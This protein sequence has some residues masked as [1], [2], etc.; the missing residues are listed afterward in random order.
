[1]GPNQPSFR[2]AGYA[3]CHIVSLDT[4][5]KEFSAFCNEKE[6]GMDAPAWLIL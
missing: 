4:E 6:V 3:E 2:N 5:K 1:V